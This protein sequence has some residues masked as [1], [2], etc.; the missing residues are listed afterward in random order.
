MSL[1]SVMLQL[2][3]EQIDEL[4]RVAHQQ[5]I[6]RSKLVRDAVDA[7]IDP[8]SDV[9]ID[10]QYARAYPTPSSGLDEWGDL[11]AWHDAA[12]RARAEAADP[13]TD[14]RGEW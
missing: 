10:E 14:G 12:R 1:K 9:T 6:S 2:S 5:G 7:L 8:P 11:D 3:E 13:S 4:D